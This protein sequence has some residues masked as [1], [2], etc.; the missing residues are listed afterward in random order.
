MEEVDDYERQSG[1]LERFLS[2]NDKTAFKKMLNMNLT[3]DK[4]KENQVKKPQFLKSMKNRKPNKYYNNY[5]IGSYENEANSLFNRYNNYSP[6]E[7]NNFKLDFHNIIQDPEFKDKCLKGNYKWGS[8]KFNQ[9]KQNLAKRRG[10]SIDELQMPKISDRKS[11]RMEMNGHLIMNNNPLANSCVIKR[12]NTVKIRNF[13]KE[14]KK[15]NEMSEF[16]KQLSQKIHCDINPLEIN[17]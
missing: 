9:I 10:I 4:E 1:L 15:E 16:S 13:M 2:K 12:T 14:K 3:S 17:I 8:M 11:D 5:G 6:G 7:I